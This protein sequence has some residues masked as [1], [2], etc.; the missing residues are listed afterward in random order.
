MLD[1]NI[2]LEHGMQYFLLITVIIPRI[3]WIIT[4]T[5]HRLLIKDRHITQMQSKASRKLEYKK[6]SPPAIGSA[7]DYTN[8]SYNLFGKLS[9][10]NITLYKASTCCLQMSTTH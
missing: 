10:W 8:Y 9:V 5:G 7:H 2:E 4:R 3:E 1:L 6:F